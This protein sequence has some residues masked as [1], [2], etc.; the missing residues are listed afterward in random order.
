[1]EPAARLIL[2]VNPHL[3]YIVAQAAAG[4]IDFFQVSA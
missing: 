2:L 1:M 3:G 4:V